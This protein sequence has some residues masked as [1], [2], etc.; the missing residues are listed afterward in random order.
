[1]LGRAGRQ[2]VRTPLPAMPMGQS[3]SGSLQETS[4]TRGGKTTAGIAKQKKLSMKK[5]QVIWLKRPLAGKA[6]KSA[7]RAGHLLGMGAVGKKERVDL[8]MQKAS[9]DL[10]GTNMPAPV[11]KNEWSGSLIKAT[12]ET[13]TSDKDRRLNGASGSSLTGTSK[14]N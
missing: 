2:K 12:I 5:G 13:S 11:R 8:G 6:G 3:G 10:Q 1:M 7:R 9:A 14:I 4:S